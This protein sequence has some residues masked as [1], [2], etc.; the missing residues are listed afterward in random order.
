MKNALIALAIAI[1]VA[2]IGHF[3]QWFGFTR[4]AI[5]ALRAETNIRIDATDAKVASNTARIESG[6]QKNREQDTRIESN[7]QKST[8]LENKNLE[9]EKRI[10]TVNARVTK[11]AI[12]ATEA[13]RKTNAD[14]ANLSEQ[15]DINSRRIEAL[16]TQIAANRN[17]GDSKARSDGATEEAKLD[18]EMSSAMVLAAQLKVPVAEAMQTEGRMPESNAKVG[19]PAPE[20]YA[21]GALARI[22]IE[23]GEIVARFKTENPNPNPGFKLIPQVIGTDASGP[24]RW[25]CVT[26]MPAASRLF[27]TCELK[28]SI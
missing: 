15:T 10:D 24:I 11:N 7:E 19:A 6:E 18:A 27:A 3:T 23:R 14:L 4:P 17:L 28:T 22:G 25:K 8:A 16:R 2:V 13:S 26:N 9:Q 1:V 20:S 5:D 12:E 21:D